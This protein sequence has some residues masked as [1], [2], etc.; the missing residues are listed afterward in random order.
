[1]IPAF[2]E[3][4]DR[5]KI[6]EEGIKTDQDVM[7]YYAEIIGMNYKPVKEGGFVNDV[8]V[9]YFATESA[10]GAL[11][12]ATLSFPLTNEEMTAEINGTSTIDW[13]EKVKEHFKKQ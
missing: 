4:G 6:S 3:A 9:V 8:G 12:G 2:A 13:R 5:F 11:L 1:M 10:K 7:V